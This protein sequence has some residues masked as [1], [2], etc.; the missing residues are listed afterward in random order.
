MKKLF[1]LFLMVTASII[2][3][4]EP[5]HNP[6]KR[7]RGAGIEYSVRCFEPKC[8]KTMRSTQSLH[9]LKL[10]LA[11]HHL[12]HQKKFT[13]LM[14]QHCDQD[15]YLDENGIWAIRCP[16]DGCTARIRCNNFSH[17]LGA[18][19]RHMATKEIHNAAGLDII[20]DYVNKHHVAKER[21]N[22]TCPRKIHETQRPCPAR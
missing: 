20:K 12:R 16:L 3:A 18:W 13:G 7:K 14:K 5:A 15:A 4:M 6:R 1:V 17:L 11:V 8:P 2:S 9:Q 21:V 10:S 19:Q 22:A